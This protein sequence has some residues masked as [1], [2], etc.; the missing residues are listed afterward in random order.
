VWRGSR[1]VVRAGCSSRN[2]DGSGG[3]GV[4]HYGGWTQSVQQESLR[5]VVVLEVL[6][7]ESWVETSNMA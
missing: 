5:V 2:R 4:S 7:T 3:G 1:G 6:W